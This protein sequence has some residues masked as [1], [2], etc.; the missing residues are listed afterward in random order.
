MEKI[1]LYILPHI[2]YNLSRQKKTSLE[3]YVFMITELIIFLVSYAFGWII[4]SH[5]IPHNILILHKN[6]ILEILQ[7]QDR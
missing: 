4:P 2:F 7:P 1:R 6:V 5:N 3:Q